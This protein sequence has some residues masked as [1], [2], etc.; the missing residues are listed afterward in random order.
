M[1]YSAVRDVT[2][3]KTLIDSVG[4]GFNMGTRQVSGQ[5]I[6]DVLKGGGGGKYRS[7]PG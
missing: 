4:K 7:E 6:V 1:F 5:D 3:T 2:S